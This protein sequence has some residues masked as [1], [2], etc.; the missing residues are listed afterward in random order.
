[1]KFLGEE[2]I[3]DD[4]V[5]S[6]GVVVQVP[7]E[8][9]TSYGKGA[10]NGPQAI[11][12]ASQ[13][14]ELY[15]EVLNCEVYKNGIIT[16]A[17]KELKKKPQKAFRQIQK[18]IKKYL[19]EDKFIIA[20]GGE[21]SIS[22]PVFELFNDKFSDFSVLQ[23]DAHADLRNSY[24]GSKYSHACVMRRVWEMNKNIVQCGIRSLSIDESEFIKEN[25][26]EFYVKDS[27]CGIK[28]QHSEKIF[29]R[30]NRTDDELANHKG[31]TGLGLAI[32]KGI[33]DQLNGD[34]WFNSVVGKGSEFYFTLPL[35]S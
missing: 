19:N 14:V 25:Q 24:E 34:I 1:M 26:I 35:N 4:P 11:I 27:G 16:S 7:Y 30:F 9:S 21:H 20:L 13:Y 5:N 18:Q 31:G 33:L 3:F 2:N 8:F 10:S 6:F 29:E 23:L 17:T 12:D 15:D 32:S 28:P 22:M